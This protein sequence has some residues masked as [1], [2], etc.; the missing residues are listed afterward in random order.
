MRSHNRYTLL[1]GAII[2]ILSGLLLLGCGGE[3]ARVV[4]NNDNADPEPVE[5]ADWV[6]STRSEDLPDGTYRGVFGDGGDMQVNVQFSVEDNETTAVSFR[7]L[8]YGGTDYLDTDDE[9]MQGIAEQYEAALDSLI[10]EDLR[11]SLGRLYEP[12]NVLGD[13]YDIDGFTG[14]TI[15]GNKIIYAVRDGL[16]RGIYRFDNA[17]PEHYYPVAAS[18]F[19]DGTYRGTFSDG[20][21]MQVNVQFTLEGNEFTNVRFRH[22]WYGGDDYLDADDDPI[23]GLRE[24]HEVLLESLVGEDVRTAL[25]GLYEPGDI[26][27]DEHDVDSFT[28]ATLRSSKV[29]SAIRDGLNRGVYGFSNGVPAGYRNLAEESFEDG[30]YRGTF[31]DGGE[32]Q[33]NVQF[34]LENNVV[35]NTSFRE[36][37]YRGTDYL[38]ADDDPV[39]GMAQQHIAALESLE[40][41]DIRGNLASLYEPGDILGDEYD[42]DGFTGATIR[43]TKIRSAIRDALNSGP[44]TLAD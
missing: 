19:Q 31:S 27:G 35:S 7:H 40:G 12:G 20:G 41:Q 21:D 39:A 8:W 2:L 25:R 28:G 16:N 13:E 24:Q 17:A 9:T 6:P 38:D 4:S 29:I 15:R 11:L 5:P 10:G 43:G 1:I 18:S 30:R 22:L 37:A 33:V 44:Y 36:L 34:D 26:V 42:V 32:M 23:A 14:A 3:R